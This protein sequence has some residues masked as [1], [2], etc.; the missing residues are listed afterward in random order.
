MGAIQ[1]FSPSKPHRRTP[2]QSHS[3]TDVLGVVLP[4]ILPA[5]EDYD[6]DHQQ[7]LRDRLQR[8]VRQGQPQEHRRLAELVERE[9]ISTTT[10]RRPR[11]HR[12][13]PTASTIQHSVISTTHNDEP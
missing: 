2:A 7:L 4:G 10:A 13:P 1:L 3:Q 6:A 12:L 11:R 5:L 8:G 9:P